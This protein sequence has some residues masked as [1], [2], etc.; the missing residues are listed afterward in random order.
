MHE[1]K[2]YHFND[3]IKVHYTGKRVALPESYRCEV[4]RHWEHLLGIG[5]KF[6]R[7]DGFTI[8]DIDIRDGCMNIITEQTDYAHF[9]YTIHKEDNMRY[10]SRV[11]YTSALVITSDGKFVIGEMNGDTAFPKKLQFVG[12]GIDRDDIDEDT[13]NLE[14][15]I[16]KEISEELGI[17]ADDKN[18]VKEFKP[19]L[20]KSGGKYNFLSAIYKLE[21][22]IDKNQLVERYIKFVQELACRGENPEL[23]NLVFVGT[24]PESVEEFIK[25]DI[26]QADENLVPVLEAAVGMYQVFDIN[27][28]SSRF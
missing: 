9:L 18:I 5:K 19:Y 23:K 21:L 1:I 15:N 17:E 3:N 25:R 24:D 2:L 22:L 12:G 13:I 16:K 20:L 11:I 14:H 4:E 7:G 6:F 28:F 8:T 26:R 27:D 10:D